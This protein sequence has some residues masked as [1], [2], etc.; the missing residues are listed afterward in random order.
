ML[1]LALVGF[2]KHIY[3]IETP[4]DKLHRNF[5]I[6]MAT[7]VMISHIKWGTYLCE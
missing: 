1:E 3:I 4:T 7:P 6:V 2:Q 5:T